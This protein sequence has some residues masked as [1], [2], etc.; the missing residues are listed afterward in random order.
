MRG[1]VQLSASYPQL[2]AGMPAVCKTVGFV[3]PG[4]SHGPAIST[5]DVPITGR[6][7]PNLGQH[8]PAVGDPAADMYGVI[9]TSSG[10]G[11]RA[12]G[13]AEEYSASTTHPDPEHVATAQVHAT[14]AL[15][16]AA[17]L[18]ND[19]GSRACV[20]RNS[21]IIEVPGR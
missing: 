13:R 10:M 7:T 17:A 4:T 21:G 20:P 11:S 2:T 1:E 15:I 16:A 12:R 6:L 9:S 14:L 3:Y 19:F 8:R 18:S 5:R